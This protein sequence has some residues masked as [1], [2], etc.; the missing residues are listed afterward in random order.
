MSGL[1]RVA[2]RIV[3][4]GFEGC[5][6]YMT[7]DLANAWVKYGNEFFSRDKWIR[8]QARSM[9]FNGGEDDGIVIEHWLEA[10]K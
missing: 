4:T 1:Y 3:E 2:W 5:G 7:Y 6:N 8:R 9:S 10:A